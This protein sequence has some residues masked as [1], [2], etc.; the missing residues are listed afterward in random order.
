MNNEFPELHDFLSAYFHQDWTVEYQSAEEVID[1]FLV[2]S[3]P[4]DLKVVLQELLVMLDQQKDELVL[5]DYLLKNMSC[6][7]CYWNLWTSGE[8]WLRHIADRLADRIDRS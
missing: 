4:E 8:S 3:A 6:Y 5:R 1:A 7:Y 2:D